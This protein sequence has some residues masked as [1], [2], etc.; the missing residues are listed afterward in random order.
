MP[1]DPLKNSI[2]F[3]RPIDASSCSGLFGFPEGL[4]Q[5][6]DRNDK[7][8]SLLKKCIS[9]YASLSTWVVYVWNTGKPGQFR[10]P[11]SHIEREW[12]RSGV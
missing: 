2:S 7:T 6:G 8:D 1:T 10:V 12:G 11:K 5:A 4:S 3:L 9:L